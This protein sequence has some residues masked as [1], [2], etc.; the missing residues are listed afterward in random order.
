MTGRVGCSGAIWAAIHKT[1]ETTPYKIQAQFNE[2]SNSTGTLQDFP[3]R[4]DT[5]S[6]AKET[7]RHGEFIRKFPPI[8]KT[9]RRHVLIDHNVNIQ[10]QETPKCH[11]RNF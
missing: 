5:D 1:Y 9:T 2:T 8:Y 3:W 10:R 11:T 6:A 4:A 7:Y